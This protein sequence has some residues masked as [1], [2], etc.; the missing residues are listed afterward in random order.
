MSV[1][2]Q[3]TMNNKGFTLIEVMLSLAIIAIIAGMSVPIYQSFQVKNDLDIAATTIAQTFRRAEMLAQ[4][5]AGDS[6]WGVH[7]GSGRI[8]LFQGTSYATRNSAY[9]EI[10]DLPLDITATGTTEFIAAHF[11]GY[12]VTAGTLTLTST[13]NET[14]TITIN[15]YGMVEY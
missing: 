14:R 13:A 6:S 9:D 7:A 4:A 8:V 1:R 12:P 3:R 11:T 5:S 10:S 2:T 15:N